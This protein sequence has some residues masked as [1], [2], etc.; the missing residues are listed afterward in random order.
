M[1]SILLTREQFRD[2][3]FGRDKFKCVVCGGPGIDAHHILDRKLFPDG[4]YYLDNGVT[5]CS[6][7][8]LLAETSDGLRYSPQKIREAASIL[9]PVLPPGYAPGIKYDKWGTPVKYPQ[10]TIL[11][12]SN[13][14]V[15]G[16]ENVQRARRLSQTKKRNLMRSLREKAAR[17]GSTTMLGMSGETQDSVSQ[18]K[19]EQTGRKL[20]TMLDPKGCRRNN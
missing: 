9:E 16:L 8:H 5:L 7:C 10:H 12:I 14:S 17:G 15:G 1:G 20:P 6:G 19:K 4:G 2:A 18:P 13:P 11:G 3:V